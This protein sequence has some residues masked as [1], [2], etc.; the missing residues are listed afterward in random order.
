M[1]RFPDSVTGPLPEIEASCWDQP[2]VP[3]KNEKSEAQICVLFVESVTAL[4]LVF[5]IVTGPLIVSVPVPTAELA[6]PDPELLICINVP[7][8]SIVPPL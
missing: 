6:P 5:V 4:L 3:A 8:E 1:T 2:M 7:P